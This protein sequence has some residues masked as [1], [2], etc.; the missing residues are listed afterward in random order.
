MLAIVVSRADDASVHIGEHLQQLADWS[1]ERDETR[2]DADGGGEVRRLDDAELRIFDTPHL[3][4]EDAAD[5]FD[6]PEMLVFASKHAGETGKLLTAH[7][8]G[9]FGPAEFGGKDGAFARACPAA[10]KRVIDAL[11][12][13]APPDYEVGM[14]C[15]HHGP[16]DPEVPSM[17]VEVGSSQPQWD[18]PDAA[19]AVAAAILDLRDVSP[20]AP[21]ENG[22]RRHLVGF[23]GGHYVPRFERIVRETDWSVGHIGADWCLDAMG[24]PEENRDVVRAAFEASA[25]DYA[26]IAENRPDLR[27]V[28]EDLGYRVVGETFLRETTDI[29]LDLVARIEDAL[30]PIESGT[31][32]GDRVTKFDGDCSVVTLPAELRDAVQGIDDEAA[33]AAVETVAV[34]FETAESGTVLGDK[35]A[36]TSPAD[37]REIIDAFVDI[38]EQK[39]DDI[40]TTAEEIVAHETAFNP[41]KAQTLGVSDGPAFGKLSAGQPVEVD[42]RT[43][44]PEAV[45]EERI[46]RFPI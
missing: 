2:S 26:L 15:T 44:P 10:H 38:L 31:R 29:P 40:E 37:R 41:E 39:Y 35:I 46:H 27:D 9:N 16:T 12:D 1:V 25:A 43:I 24:D 7:H 32:F 20:D 4:L 17:F 30:G 11:V 21:H 5:A 22:T 34:A 36:I 13:H 42:G 6:D 3:E 33:R 28:V 14:E 18:D 8:T 45:H 23:G 19:R